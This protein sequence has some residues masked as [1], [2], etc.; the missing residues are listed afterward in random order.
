MPNFENATTARANDG[1]WKRPV[2]VTGSLII[3][4]LFCFSNQCY[5]DM[6]TH[7][8]AIL[9]KINTCESMLKPLPAGNS[10]KL[11]C[12]SIVHYE[13]KYGGFF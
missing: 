1:R 2:N 13:I 7:L 6:E 12:H 8:R 5:F 9:L 4:F 11:F 10:L 3:M